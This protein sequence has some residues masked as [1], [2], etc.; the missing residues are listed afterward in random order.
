MA[1]R[2]RT[3]PWHDST[4]GVPAGWP[5][6]LRAATSI[7]LRS[8]YPMILSWGGDFVMLYNDAFIPTL[9]DKHPTA[10]GGRLAEQ[11]SEIWDEIRPLQE[12]VLAGGEATW[13][14]DLP[15]VIERGQGPEETFFTFSYSPV[16][17]EDRPGGVLA[18]LSVTTPEVV[19]SRRLA[20]LKDIGSV[21]AVEG[22]PAA[23]SLARVLDAHPSELPGGRLWWEGPE[24]LEPV[25]EFGEPGAAPPAPA[26]PTDLDRARA[27]DRVWLRLGPGAPTGLLEVLLP[28]LRP[29][30]GSHRQFLRQL[31][32]QV[33]Q[34][35][36]A[37]RA[38]ELEVASS[39]ALAELDEAKTQFLST[40][41]HE[42]R[43][44]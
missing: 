1:G 14:E 26:P 16:P 9:G 11:F 38:R 21:A 31:A 35:L 43:T 36:D 34:Q 30:D 27:G 12:G 10:L 4:L 33:A 28:A 32:Q 44:R 13:D 42:L 17:D 18:V 8:K 19:G 23:R 3:H 2:M 15:L 37:A 20:L 40:M 6:A 7:L 39:R 29:L 25:A 41:S 24:G 5:Q 22:E